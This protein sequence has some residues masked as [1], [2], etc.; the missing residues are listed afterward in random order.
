MNTV[1]GLCTR[2]LHI[3]CSVVCPP[4]FDYPHLLLGCGL[5]HEASQMDHTED[6]QICFQ[7]TKRQMIEYGIYAR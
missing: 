3:S 2:D 1:N 6:P 4:D 7:A 5:L